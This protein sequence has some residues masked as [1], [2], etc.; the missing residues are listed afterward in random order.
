MLLCDPLRDRTLN[1]VKEHMNTHTQKKPQKPPSCCF[2]P[3][4]F[5]QYILYL[6]TS[7]KAAEET[8]VGQA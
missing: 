8:A 6:D 7:W 2:E 3:S 1:H 5:P 4:S